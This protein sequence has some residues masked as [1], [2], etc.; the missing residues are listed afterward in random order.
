MCRDL[1]RRHLLP[2]LSRDRSA[3][4]KQE[5]EG[6][7]YTIEELT[8]NRCGSA[9]GDDVD[10]SPCRHSHLHA[11]WG[12]MLMACHCCAAA[13]PLSFKGVDI[14]L[15]SAGGSISKTLGPVAAAA[16]S[17]VGLPG[18]FLHAAALTACCLP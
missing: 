11:W 17:V 6:V 1:I 16:G 12:V 13:S 5:F 7:S 3:G 18:R 14:A 9:E 15:F 8:E 2:R 10:G 4:K